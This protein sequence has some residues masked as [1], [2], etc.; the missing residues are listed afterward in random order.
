MV[1]YRFNNELVSLDMPSHFVFLFFP[2]VLN[3]EQHCAITSGVIR[4]KSF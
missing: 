4:S 2:G 1:R 3:P